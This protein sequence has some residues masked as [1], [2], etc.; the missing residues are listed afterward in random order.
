MNFSVW[1]N[2]LGY[3]VVGRVSQKRSG[4]GSALLVGEGKLKEIA[5]WTG[6]PGV[7]ANPVK[8]KKSKAAER[9]AREDDDAED[10]DEE[11]TND[12]G[13]RI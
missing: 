12:P 5:K 9:F 10:G 11:F 7:I 8:K 1:L 6:G 2:T 4:T 3:D 13:S